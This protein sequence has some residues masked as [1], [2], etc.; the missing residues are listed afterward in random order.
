MACAYSGC[1]GS[2]GTQVPM[3]ACP[4]PLDASGAYGPDVWWLGRA[5]RL[6]GVYFHR[7]RLT[8]VEERAR[9]LDVLQLGLTC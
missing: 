7:R 2:T 8:F 9:R 5:Q 4:D 1:A 3:K 6:V